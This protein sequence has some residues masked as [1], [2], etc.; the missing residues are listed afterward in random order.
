LVLDPIL[1]IAPPITK[2]SPHPKPGWAFPAV[3]PLI[4]SGYWNVEVFTEFVDTEESIT[5]FHGMECFGSAC[6]GSVTFDFD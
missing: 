2:M 4:E 5:D 3:A 6:H 1:D